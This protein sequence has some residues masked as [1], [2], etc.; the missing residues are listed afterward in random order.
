[1]YWNDYKTK[2]GNKDVT[3]EYRYFLGSNFVGVNWLFVLVYLNQ[4]YDVKRYNGEKY[5]FPKGMYYQGS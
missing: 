2:R 5:D 4:N 3:N 1:M